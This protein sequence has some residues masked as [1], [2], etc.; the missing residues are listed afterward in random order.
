MRPQTVNVGGGYYCELPHSTRNCEPQRLSFKFLSRS[1]EAECEDPLPHYV[2][3]IEP[4]LLD[5][6][7][8]HSPIPS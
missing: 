7:G 6:Y 8:A 4:R 1:G 2:F 3:T 5:I